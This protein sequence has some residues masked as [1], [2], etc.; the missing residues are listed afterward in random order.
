MDPSYL[1]YTCNF[2]WVKQW[3]KEC[4]RQKSGKEEAYEGEHGLDA[5]EVHLGRYTHKGNG[6]DEGGHQG[7]GY[8]EHAE[9]PSAKQVLGRRAIPPPPVGLGK[10]QN[11]IR[12]QKQRKCGGG[13]GVNCKIRTNF[14]M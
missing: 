3:H 4:T 12:Y 6:G 14:K 11:V 7:E 9:P 2:Q 10:W 8:R 13:G 1:L 5:I